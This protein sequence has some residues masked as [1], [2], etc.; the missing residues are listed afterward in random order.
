MNVFNKLRTRTEKYWFYSE[1]WAI[2]PKVKKV[3]LVI[4]LLNAFFPHL[5]NVSRCCVFKR[6]GTGQPG[7]GPLCLILGL[8][9]AGIW[10]PGEKGVAVP[11]S[12][13][14]LSTQPRG[15]RQPDTSPGVTSSSAGLSGCQKE[16]EADAWP[17]SVS[18]R[19]WKKQLLCGCAGGI[20]SSL[21]NGRVD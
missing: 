6:E 17:R 16:Q 4:N 1:G 11:S 2:L 10:D 15:G 14:A 19:Q 20:R 13:A 9:P 3:W 12:K 5:L 21:E 8:H 7:W 18:L